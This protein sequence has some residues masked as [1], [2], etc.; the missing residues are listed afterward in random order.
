MDNFA[1]NSEAAA[2]KVSVGPNSHMPDKPSEKSSHIVIK[3]IDDAKGMLR[4]APDNETDTDKLPYTINQE[5]NLETKDNDPALAS[6]S[7]SNT[8]PES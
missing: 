5:D 4:E 6:V 8:A 1:Q 7:I 3:Y 2:Y